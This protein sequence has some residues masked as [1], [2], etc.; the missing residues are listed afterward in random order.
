MLVCQYTEQHYSD[1][2]WKQ[3]PKSTGSPADKGVYVHRMDCGAPERSEGLAWDCDLREPGAL[4]GDQVKHVSVAGICR[5]PATARSRHFPGTVAR[6]ELIFLDSVEFVFGL[7]EILEREI[8]DIV[9][10]IATSNSELHSENGSSERL[11]STIK[12]ITEKKNQCF[13]KNISSR[14]GNTQVFESL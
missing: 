13:E 10:V 5:Q 14:E 6:G 12:C 4:I 11:C 2:K 8:G 7:E 1:K 9:S 3:P